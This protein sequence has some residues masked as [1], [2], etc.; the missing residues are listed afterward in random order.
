MECEHCH[1]HNPPGRE[2]CWNCGT[3]L[4]ASTDDDADVKAA[5]AGA[6][7]APDKRPSAEDTSELGTL[8]PLR[9]SGPSERTAPRPE[10][11]V[12]A[13]HVSA[14]RGA[15]RLLVRSIIAGAVTGG[16]ALGVV[17]GLLAEAGSGILEGGTVAVYVAQGFIVG[18]INGAIIGALSAY[19]GGG[20]WTGGKVGGALAAGMWFAQMLLTGTI[21]GTPAPIVAAEVLVMALAGAAMGALVGGVVESISPASH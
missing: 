12:P 13:D 3:R 6:R 18:A 11:R 14:A 16:G 15:R 7:A 1:Q 19:Y 20:I 8:G 4:G 10:S 2:T 17:T 21:A 9:L 5:A